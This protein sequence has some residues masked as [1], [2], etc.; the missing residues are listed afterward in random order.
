MP[1]GIKNTA[2]NKMYGYLLGTNAFNRFVAITM[3]VATNNDPK[4][5]L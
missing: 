1:K 2:T 3:M 4:R 5:V